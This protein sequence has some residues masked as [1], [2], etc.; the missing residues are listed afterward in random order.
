M[1]QSLCKLVRPVTA[2]GDRWVISRHSPWKHSL[3]VIFT[4]LFLGLVG[5]GLFALGRASVDHDHTLA[6]LCA[7]DDD[8]V[9]Q[10]RKDNASLREQT[11]MLERS[12]QIERTAYSR[13]AESLKQLRE[14]THRLKEELAIYKGIV[15]RSDLDKGIIIQSVKLRPGGQIGLYRYQIVLTHFGV[16]KKVISGSM[17]ILISGTQ[18]RK[19][20]VLSLAELAPDE[21]SNPEGNPEIHFQFRNFV[22]VDGLLHL[23]QDFKPRHIRVR[24]D[25]QAGQQQVVERTFTW[26]Q[27]TS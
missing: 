6:E 10:L 2:A 11:V 7:G 8:R 20:S 25:A 4:A 27:A 12:D 5:W 22:R 3:R 9:A 24:V 13:I 16:D 18:G 15:I 14:E 26:E 23:P 1:P 17:E 21:R 19:P